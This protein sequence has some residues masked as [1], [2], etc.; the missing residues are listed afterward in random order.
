MSETLF[1]FDPNHTDK[2]E[3]LS[4]KLEIPLSTERP[5]KKD[6]DKLWLEWIEDKKTSESH[7][8]LCSASNGPV[9]I[10]FISG[11]K[12]HRMQFGGGKGQPLIRAMGV[13]E[14]DKT[15]TVFDATAGMG[16]DSFV[17]ATQ[18]FKVIMSERSPI[19]AALL[20]DALQRADQALEN[21]SKELQ[22]SIENLSLINMDS[23]DFLKQQDI[24]IDVVYMDPMYPEKKKKAA[25]KKEMQALQ[26]LVG[27]DLDS[28]TLL[29]TALQTAKSR[30]VV[31]RPKGAEPIK[32][33]R[34]GV[35]PSTSISS[36]NTR[37]D[38]YVIKAL[39]A[40]LKNPIYL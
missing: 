14:I 29:D 27:P 15:T 19:V 36:P 3:S 18:G 4:K 39:A 6:K 25:V 37:Y 22:Q 40:P 12:A 5:H 9:H 33:L 13:Q 2:A 21:L 16:G 17:L 24:K 28:A 8:A 10:D 34:F 1:I 23:A 30:V 35:E 32:S 7:L 38:I 26:Q 11:K 20:D 31:K